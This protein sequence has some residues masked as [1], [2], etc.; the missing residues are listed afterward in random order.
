MVRA[1]FVCTSK[2]ITNEG[3]EDEGFQIGLDA[4]T[5]GSEE[6]ENFFKMT[7]AA[8]MNLSTINPKAAEQ[9]EVGKEY[10]IDFSPADASDD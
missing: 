5:S 7:P 4:V 9:F 6:N 1:K 3:T 10:Y 2:A 8:S